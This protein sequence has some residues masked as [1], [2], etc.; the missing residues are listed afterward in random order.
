MIAL[1]EPTT[2]INRFADR[3]AKLSGELHRV[4]TDDEQSRHYLRRIGV[5]LAD[6]ATIIRTTPTPTLR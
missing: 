2:R 6:A 1:N 5:H 4:R 3:C